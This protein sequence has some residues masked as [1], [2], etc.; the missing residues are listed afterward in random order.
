MDQSLKA[1]S[2][3]STELDELSL[4]YKKSS[5]KKIL[6]PNGKKTNKRL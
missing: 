5:Y 2:P 1:D 3:L 6:K 4:V